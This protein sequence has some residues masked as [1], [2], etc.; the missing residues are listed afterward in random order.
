MSLGN[1]IN[2][3]FEALLNVSD[4]SFIKV[5]IKFPT[6]VRIFY[7]VTLQSTQAHN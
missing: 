2:R 6:R 4:T 5:Y 7:H 1:H 3:T